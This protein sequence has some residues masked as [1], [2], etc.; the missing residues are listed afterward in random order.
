MKPKLFLSTEELEKI[1]SDLGITAG[2]IETAQKQSQNHFIRAQG[3]FKLKHWDDAI[4]ELQ[5]AIAFNPSNLEMLLLLANSHFGRWDQKHSKEDQEQ[6]KF[7]IR[8]CLEIKP[9]HEESLK[10]IEKIDSELLKYQQIKLVFTSIGIVLIGVLIGFLGVNK[11]NWNFLSNQDSKLEVLE[12]EFKEEINNL[13]KE[14]DAAL[15]KFIND[16]NY[17]HKVN[18]EK[19]TQAEQKIRKLEQEIKQLNE[20]LKSSEQ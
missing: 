16:E 11:I 19:V 9:D 12:R 2:E 1:A 5:E 3:Y 4:T 8:Q 20:K 17:K 7:R 14:Q 13:K 6:I 18:Q 10:L 15:K